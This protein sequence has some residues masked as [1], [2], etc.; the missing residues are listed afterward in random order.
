MN[1]GK[2]K[3]NFSNNESLSSILL[4]AVITNK[5]VRFMDKLNR[6]QSS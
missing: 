2:D 4:L 5:N 6:Y 3:L 1:E